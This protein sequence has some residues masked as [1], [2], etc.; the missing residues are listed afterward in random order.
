MLKILKKIE[1]FE[2]NL[3]KK[4]GT[5]NKDLIV[6]LIGISFYI[7]YIIAIKL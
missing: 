7:C 1:K 3:D 6:V 4:I 5:K 2:K